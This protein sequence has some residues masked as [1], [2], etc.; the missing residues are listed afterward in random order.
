MNPNPR[1][2]RPSAAAERYSIS[3]STLAQWRCRGD[4][5]RFV[6]LSP[7]VVVYDVDEFDRWVAERSVSSTTQAERLPG[8]GSH[9]AA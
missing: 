4:G 2:I 9:V 7:T 3:P 1:Y 8:R 5:P 6:K